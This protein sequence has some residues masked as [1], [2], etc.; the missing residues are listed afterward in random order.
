MRREPARDPEQDAIASPHMCLQK[1]GHTS[2][3]ALFFT[4]NLVKSKKKV[5]ASVDVQFSTKNLMKSKN[6][7][8]K[9]LRL[10]MT[11]CL[12][13]LAGPLKT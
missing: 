9:G 10:A 5:I 1:K 7:K 13:K 6:I 2:A 12:A 11:L 8:E 4:Q 3:D